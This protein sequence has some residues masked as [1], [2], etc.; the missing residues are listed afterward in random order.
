MGLFRNDATRIGFI[1]I[2]IIFIFGSFCIYDVNRMLN[3]SSKVIG[4]FQHTTDVVKV[5]DFEYDITQLLFINS[6]A[7]E[8]EYFAEVKTSP[9]EGFD[10]T[11]KYTIEV[12]GNKCGYVDKSLEYVNTNFINTF[13]STNN[14]VLL[15]DKLNIKVNFYKD[16]T[17][18]VLIT[19]NGEQAVKLW[20]SYIQ[21]NGFKLKIVEDNFSSVIEADKLPNYTINLYVG[22]ELYKTLEVNLNTQKNTYLPYIIN[23]INIHS[24]KDVDGNIYDKVPLKNIDLYGTIQKAL[25]FDINDATE[26][27]VEKLSDYCNLFAYRTYE[28]RIFKSDEERDFVNKLTEKINGEINVSNLNGFNSF[29]FSRSSDSYLLSTP[30][31]YVPSTVERREADCYFYMSFC[32]S[33]LTESSYVFSMNLFLE[34]NINCNPVI[35]SDGVEITLSQYNAVKNQIISDFTNKVF[36]FNLSVK[37]F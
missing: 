16:G 37:V 21:K 32:V 36:T 20:S 9:V 12:N 26:F 30:D 34:D 6:G 19:N 1:L 8:K 23:D 22:E 7:N 29:K 18:I 14:T 25:T 3:L 13:Y 27:K 11:K 15:T 28:T 24:W 31:Y 2:A 4:Y 33:S 35:S 17:K 5:N 10:K